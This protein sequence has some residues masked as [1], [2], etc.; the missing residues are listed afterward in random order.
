MNFDI[1]KEA[2]DP[3][4]PQTRYFIADV[5]DSVL[6]ISFYWA[7]KV[8]A[9]DPPTLNGPLISAISITPGDLK[10]Y[11]FSFF[12]LVPSNT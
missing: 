1:A 11:D 2:K 12:W 7:G 5:S 9:D 4:E 3:G 10:G 8:C 6:E